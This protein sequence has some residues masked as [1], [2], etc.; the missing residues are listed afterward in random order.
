MTL[1]VDGRA[2]VIESAAGR[3]VLGA[4]RVGAEVCGA[5]VPDP[6][7]FTRD[8]GVAREAITR[9][10][11][12]Y[13]LTWTFDA[14]PSGDV[15][16][17][18]PIDGPSSGAVR[19]R[20]VEYP[21][22]RGFLTIGAASLV[23]ARGIVTPLAMNVGADLA[24]EIVVPSA[25]LA[26]ASY[27]IVIDP[28]IGM[29]YEIDDRV[30]EL[31]T[32]TTN[33]SDL[34]CSNDFCVA[35]MWLDAAGHDELVVQLFDASGAPMG[36]VL[37]L[38][39]D[40]PPWGPSAVFAAIEGN[41]AL[42]SDG[43]RRALIRSDSVIVVPWD[44][45]PAP[46]FP[47]VAMT[48]PM[49]TGTGAGSFV[50]LETLIRATDLGVL[51]HSGG[52][53]FACSAG[54]CL[55]QGGGYY[56]NRYDVSSGQFVLVDHPDI[57]RAFDVVAASPSIVDGFDLLLDGIA[58]I[59]VRLTTASASVIVDGSMQTQFTGSGTEFVR[60]GTEVWATDNYVGSQY[61]FHTDLSTGSTATLDGDASRPRFAIGRTRS[62]VI[63]IGRRTDEAYDAFLTILTPGA[64]AVENTE[65]VAQLRSGGAAW[66]DDDGADYVVG[67][68][69]VRTLGPD[70]TRRG[71]ILTNWSSTGVVAGRT[72]LL[73]GTE[74]YALPALTPLSPSADPILASDHDHFV[75]SRGFVDPNTFALISPLGPP[76]T[77]GGPG[78]GRGAIQSG[79]RDPVLDAYSCATVRSGW[80]V[81]RPSPIPG[82]L[83]WP[84]LAS[85]EFPSTFTTSLLDRT[86]VVS[87]SCAPPTCT[88]AL[89]SGAN[90]YAL[91]QLAPGVWIAAA[92]GD[93]DPTTNVPRSLWLDR[94]VDAHPTERQLV[95]DGWALGGLA[96]RFPNTCALTYGRWVG[97]PDFNQRAMLRL[98]SFVGAGEPC[99]DDFDCV[100]GTCAR[101]V[102]VDPPPVDAG[103]DAAASDAGLDAAMAVDASARDAAVL[104]AA[105]GASP[106]CGCRAVPGPGNGGLLVLLGLLVARRRR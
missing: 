82:T 51:D 34:A 84:E 70:L 56:L 103:V 46:F 6:I 40:V 77:L 47:D 23:D 45:W 92:T 72:L 87:S 11:A 80:I 106:H 18:V 49:A 42:V 69:H 66:I 89:L 81:A 96:C 85:I 88:T 14:A 1:D 57:G 93:L 71:P 59:V 105:S 58:P 5:A 101:S 12:G 4:T 7:S 83:V 99:S 75:T 35:V 15:H 8:C 100:R 65:W 48:V 27:P 3:V 41:T 25:A 30:A 2:T 44:L 55:T 95:I 29:E 94:F 102:C 21:L 19:G 62:S 52:R 22:A 39:S 60:I 67:Y 98:I 33:P 97:Y 36:P 76:P 54:V 50:V 63:A 31:L 13:E 78:S 73:G 37:E 91:D 28:L 53:V 61:I 10:F 68:G 86:P 38:P 43:V 20:G 17:R 104:D 90:A 9:T 79:T 32:S 16:I 26:S 24:L 64:S 74:L